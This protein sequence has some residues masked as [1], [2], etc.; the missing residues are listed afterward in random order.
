[1]MVLW[2]WILAFWAGLSYPQ[3]F[4]SAKK[5]TS[6]EQVPEILQE[7]VFGSMGRIRAFWQWGLGLRL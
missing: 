3:I 2:L 4:D 6:R 5:P 7:R 1:M